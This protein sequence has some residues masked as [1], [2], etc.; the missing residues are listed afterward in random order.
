MKK[1]IVSVVTLVA[2]VGVMALLLA[3]T[4][5]DCQSLAW[6]ISGANPVISALSITARLKNENRSQSS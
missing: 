2:I 6:M 1:H 5:A 4:N 3:G